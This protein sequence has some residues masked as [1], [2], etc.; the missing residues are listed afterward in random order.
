MTELRQAIADALRR[1]DIHLPNDAQERVVGWAAEVQKHGKKT[2]LI[3]TTDPKRIATELVA[4]SLMILPI[5]EN[6]PD[7]IV[8][9][10]A[11]AGVPGLILCAALNNAGILVEPRRKRTLFLQHCARSLGLT[12]RVRAH[13][14]RIE[15][16]DE[17]TFDTPG[18][19][20]WV[21]RAV[22]A[23]PQWLQVAAAHA[24]PGDHV[25]L[26]CNGHLE[27]AHIDSPTKTLQLVARRTY[28]I[29]GPGDRTIFVFQ[30]TESN[31]EIRQNCA[32]TQ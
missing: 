28:S 3:G 1:H 32:E 7:T 19:R 20:L 17:T 25:G 14:A 27:A 29:A 9:I 10:G 26:W 6:T 8:D 5:L 24:R 4:D 30:R 21:S 31:D 23:P 15:D 2:N 22:F 13:E 18:A 16:L 12:P 11:G